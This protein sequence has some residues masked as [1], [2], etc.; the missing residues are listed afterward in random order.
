[1]VT[2]DFGDVTT[3]CS[4]NQYNLAWMTKVASSDSVY[5]IREDSSLSNGSACI[6]FPSIEI[7][8]DLKRL[9]GDAHIV[10]ILRPDF[11]DETVAVDKGIPQLQVTDPVLRNKVIELVSIATR[12][13]PI[14][15]QISGKYGDT[16]RSRPG[17]LRVSTSFE[18]IDDGAFNLKISWVLEGDRIGVVEKGQRVFEVRAGTLGSVVRGDFD[19]RRI[20]APGEGS[21]IGDVSLAHGPEALYVSAE[22]N[23]RFVETVE[24]SSAGR[25]VRDRRDGRN[26]IQRWSSAL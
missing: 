18:R 20:L 8:D 19:S 9:L 3:D 25:F 13:E 24:I 7:R 2:F 26:S 16:D 21:L 17:T 1:M 12:T 14:P 6:P 4:S 11:N 22:A 10:R 23:S 5:A 15:A